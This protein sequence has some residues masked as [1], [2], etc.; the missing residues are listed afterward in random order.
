MSILSDIDIEKLLKKDIVIYPYG[1]EC[2]SPI[3]YDLRIGYAINLADDNSSKISFLSL[4]TNKTIEVPAKTSTLIITKE[5]IYLSKKIAGTLH[6]RGSLAARGIFINSTTVD[7]NWN[8][9][10]TFLIYNN[11]DKSIELD[12]ESRFVTLICHKVNTPTLKMPQ[13]NPIS[14]AQKYGDI[15]GE[16]FNK[17]ILGYLT[18]SGNHLLNQEFDK[19]VQEAKRPGLSDITYDIFIWMLT[20]IQEFTNQKLSM[21]VVRILLIIPIGLIFIGLT[22]SLTWD[23]IQS[24]LHLN[25]LYSPTFI[26]VQVAM[27]VGG[28]A[29]FIGLMNLMKAK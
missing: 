17:S 13:T 6:A 18:S 28:L 15:Y 5:Y 7:P 27:L 8:G 24:Y 1:E 25:I 14:V 2:I 4:E 20:T 10:L 22:A 12:I 19:L 3:G 11:N 21:L 26:S 29:S 16:V 9:Q 23:W